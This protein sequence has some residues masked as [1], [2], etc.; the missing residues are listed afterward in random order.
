MLVGTS[1]PHQEWR[2][3][4]V[5]G[6]EGGWRREGYKFPVIW[7]LIVYTWAP[8]CVKAMHKYTSAAAWGGGMGYP[9]LC[10]EATVGAVAPGIHPLA[11]CVVMRIGHVQI[12][13]NAYNLS[14]SEETPP[15]PSTHPTLKTK[16]YQ[17][18]CCLYSVIYLIIKHTYTCTYT[19]RV[20]E[21]EFKVAHFI[22]D[23]LTIGQADT[24]ATPFLL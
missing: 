22:R 8:H 3:S 12:F 9:V 15:P 24:Q 7:V 11:L 1:N 19:A 21:G 4:L 14:I 23:P 13:Q 2:P 17:K 6:A 16:N 18:M 20:G 5:V 10:R